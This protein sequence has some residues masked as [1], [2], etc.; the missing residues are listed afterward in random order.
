MQIKHRISNALEGLSTLRGKETREENGVWFK[1][2]KFQKY[3]QKNPNSVDLDYFECVSRGWAG[4][5][6]IVTDGHKNVLR[7]AKGILGRMFKTI[8]K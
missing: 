8:A 2:N 6:V 7:L 1:G 5:D 4:R 3:F